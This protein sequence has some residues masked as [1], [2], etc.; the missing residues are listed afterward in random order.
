MYV[1]QCKRNKESINRYNGSTTAEQI[2]DY[3]DSWGTSFQSQVGNDGQRVINIPPVYHQTGEPCDLLTHRSIAGEDSSLSPETVL[4]SLA[5]NKAR[6]PDR[7]LI[8]HL[9]HETR[10][11]ENRHVETRGESG[12]KDSVFAETRNLGILGEKHA[13]HLS[14]LLTFTT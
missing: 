3:F 7:E 6:C 5:R 4:V 10:G 8:P 14:L 11:S 12:E 2:R 9:K 1:G 13:N